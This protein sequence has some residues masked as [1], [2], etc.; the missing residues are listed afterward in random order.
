MWNIFEFPPKIDIETKGILKMA[1]RARTA[2]AE[3]K[4]VAETIPN[5]Y[6]LLNALVLQEA[7]DSSAIE[8]IITTHDE[9][10]KAELNIVGVN[11]LAAKEVQNYATALK[12]GYELVKSKQLLTT[13]YVIQIQEV[14]EKNKAGFRKVPGTTLKN[15][16]GIV[17]YEPPQNEQ[18]IIQLMSK[19]EY[20]INDDEFCEWDDLIKMAMIHF[21]FESI[22]PFYDGNGRTG[23]IMNVLYLQKQQ[24]LNMPILYLSRYINQNKSDYYRLLQDVRDS[25]N[26]SEWV[27]YMLVAIEKTAIQAIGIVKEMGQLMLIFKN[28]MRSE[29]PKIY[30]QDLLNNLFKHPYTKI[31]FV[32]KDLQVSR[33]T[34]IKY[35]DLIDGIGLLYKQKIGKSNYYVNTALVNLFS[36]DYTLK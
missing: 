19:L 11:F 5:Q 26:W 13:N 31:E 4:G 32:Q 18:D 15:N 2:L 9:L 33:L 20:F 6:L 12:E 25:E 10:F 3:L 1:G 35:L 22:H 30:S 14:L 7:K 29:L 27:M 34:A 28:K 17:I 24:L 21:Q 36:K 23:R 16:S 8:N